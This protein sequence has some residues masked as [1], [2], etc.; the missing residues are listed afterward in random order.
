MRIKA[1]CYYD[2]DLAITVHVYPLGKRLCCC[3][4]DAT[5]EPT[6]R[7]RGGYGPRAREAV[8]NESTSSRTSQPQQAE[9]KAHE[10]P[11]Q[12]KV[13]KP[14]PKEGHEPIINWAS[15]KWN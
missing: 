3:G 8:F 7:G 5:P 9:E 12:G 4:I 14:K 6:Q 1:V 2:A 10:A 13:E 15:V 11:Q